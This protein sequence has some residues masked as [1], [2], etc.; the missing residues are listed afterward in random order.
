MNVSSALDLCPSGRAKRRRLCVA[1]HPSIHHPVNTLLTLVF[2]DVGEV[3][4]RPGW[5]HR[6]SRN[7]PWARGPVIDKGP[8]MRCFGP[9]KPTASSPGGLSR[10]DAPGARRLWAPPGVSRSKHHANQTA[11]STVKDGE[12]VSAP[13]TM[14]GSGQLLQPL[15]GGQA[16]KSADARPGEAEHHG[17]AERRKHSLKAARCGSDWWPGPDSQHIVNLVQIFT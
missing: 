15:V 4:R 9:S 12:L 1:K 3:S 13:L 14:H 5:R 8:W 2:S 7:R 10:Q 16:A 11:Q 6:G 17:R